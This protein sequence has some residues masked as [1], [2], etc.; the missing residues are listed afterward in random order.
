V[1]QELQHP[2]LRVSDPPLVAWL[3][4]DRLEL[5]NQALPPLRASFSFCHFVLAANFYSSHPSLMSFHRQRQWHDVSGFFLQKFFPKSSRQ[6]FCTSTVLPVRSEHFGLGGKVRQNFRKILFL[7]RLGERSEDFH[8][9]ASKMDVLIIIGL[10]FHKC[11]Q[12]QGYSAESIL[13]PA[14]CYFHQEDP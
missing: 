6:L 3:L 9:I 8:R 7:I 14:K 10:G 2:K 12:N 13:C 1:N 5:S 11:M 4:D